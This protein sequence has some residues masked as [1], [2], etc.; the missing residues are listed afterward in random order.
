M[1]ILLPTPLPV[2]SVRRPFSQTLIVSLVVM[3]GFL[4]AL[5]LL[6][7]QSG[8][9]PSYMM[10][11]IP[12]AFS[13]W[14]GGSRPAATVALAGVLAMDIWLVSPGILFPHTASLWVDAIA[15][16]VGTFCILL[17]ASSFRRQIRE[18]SDQLVTSEAEAQR[19]HLNETNLRS[20]VRR[21]EEES[22][23]R[24]HEFTRITARLRSSEERMRVAQESARFCLFDWSHPGDGIVVFGDPAPLFG[25]DGGAWRGRDSLLAKVHPDDAVRLG[26]VLEA[27]PQARRP[28]DVEVRFGEGD[29]PRW[30]AVRGQTTFTRKGEPARTIGIFLDVTEK[31]LTEQMLVRTEKLAAAGRLAAAIA[32]EV[33]NPLAAATNLLYIIKGDGSLSRSGRQYVEMA[34][35][36]LARLGRIARRT[37][38]F[39]RE[40]TSPSK[41]DL[42]SVLDDVLEMYARNLPAGIK[43]TKHYRSGPPAEVVEGEIRQ[44]LG[45]ILVNAVQAMGDN[46]TIDLK[47]EPVLR[48]NGK[49]WLI[50]VKDT[51]PGIPDGDLRSLF[52][53]FFTRKGA[54]TGLGLWIARQIIER[55]GGSIAVESRTGSEEHGTVVTIFLPLEQ[56]RAQAADSVA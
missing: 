2:A 33:N 6:Q 12:V 26:A 38:G 27:V 30:I 47:V 31:K 23:V 56:E 32:H 9:T 44:V 14:Y 5:K 53:P 55:H 18:L 42:A 34:E 17:F 39:Y 41:V 54:G 10:L 36:E 46:G 21:L 37:L 24:A 48:P 22:R 20:S 8:L 16:A 49:G 15:F 52:E 13:A 19:Y 7:V 4:A 50:V 29:R 40:S 11:L 1:S 25:V 45:N 3:V 43:V 28:L 51:G 35:Q